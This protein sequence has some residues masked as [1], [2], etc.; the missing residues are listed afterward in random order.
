MKEWLAC[1]PEGPCVCSR[2][3]ASFSNLENT[4][5]NNGL[6]CQSLRCVRLFVTKVHNP[7]RQIASKKV[8]LDLA[9]SLVNFF[10]DISVGYLN[11]LIYFDRKQAT[12]YSLSQPSHFLALTINQLIF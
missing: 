7:K 10:N 6:T 3:P 8:H 12:L 1:H 2:T 11:I 4:A 5:V 9:V